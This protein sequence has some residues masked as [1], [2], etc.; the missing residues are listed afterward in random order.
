M[1]GGEKR[2]FPHSESSSSRAAESGNT[3]MEKQTAPSGRSVECMK[4]IRKAA[5]V[6]GTRRQP[7]SNKR[8]VNQPFPSAEGERLL[9]PRQWL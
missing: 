3:D 4:G 8:R 6:L 9:L 2:T 1:G 5:V 7:A